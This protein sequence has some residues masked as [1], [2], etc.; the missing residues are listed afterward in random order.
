MQKLTLFVLLLSVALPNGVRAN[1]EDSFKQAAFPVLFLIG[2]IGSIVSA[3]LSSGA[4][5]FVASL[6]GNKFL[7]FSQF[8]ITLC[9]VFLIFG[10]G[11]ANMLGFQ[12]LMFVALSI[13]VSAIGS[14]LAKRMLML[15]GGFNLLGLMGA[16][17]LFNYNTPIYELT[18]LACTTYFD[19]AGWAND[20]C[21]DDGFL[22]LIRVAGAAAI[23]LLVAAIGSH[24]VNEAHGNPAGANKKTDERDTLV[25]NDHQQEQHHYQAAESGHAEQKA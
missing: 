2:G 3:V 15:F 12:L 25:D 23:L 20:R 9:G 10:P 1:G 14:S 19:N 7:A 4:T 21:K 22:Q 16:L 11:R 24:L 6:I 8:L 18:T 17:Y 13:H 5:A